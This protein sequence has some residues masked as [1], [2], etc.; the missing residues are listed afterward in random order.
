MV[1]RFKGV[2]A[3]RTNAALQR[4]GPLWDVGFHDHA[5]RSDESVIHAARYIV[6]NPVR[7]GL[8]KRV[9]DYPFWDAI[10]LD[11]DRSTC[12]V[13]ATECDAPAFGDSND[14]AEGCG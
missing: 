4:R 5:L 3:R 13:G 8:V 12:A 1:R 7:A 2:V 10:W 6:A 11:A 14:A 9:G